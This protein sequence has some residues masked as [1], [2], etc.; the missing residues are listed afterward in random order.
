MKKY[1]KI[2][3]GYNVSDQVSIEESELEKALYAQLMKKPVQLGNSFVSGSH[4]ISI[5]PHYHKHTGWYDW[6]EPSTGEDWVQ[7]ERDCPN[8]SG[9]VEHYKQRV[10]YLLSNNMENKIGKNIEIQ[11]LKL[12]L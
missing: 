3:Y 9:V 4:I 8:Y 1:F 5:T 12:N 7:I 2:K 11:G 6:Y 10:Q